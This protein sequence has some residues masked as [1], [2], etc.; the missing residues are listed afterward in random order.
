MDLILLFLDFI[1]RPENRDE[2]RGNKGI[3]DADFSPTYRF[4]RKLGHK[5]LKMYGEGFGSLEEKISSEAKFLVQRLKGT[6]EK[7]VDV[8]FM[9]GRLN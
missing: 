3:L 9:I 5:A 7:P 2:P 8:R 1:G 4:N 6:L